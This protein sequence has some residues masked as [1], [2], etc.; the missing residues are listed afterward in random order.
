MGS[1]GVP[2]RDRSRIPSDSSP[3]GASAGSDYLR[4][5][6]VGLS[7]VWLCAGLSA[8]TRGPPNAVWASRD[9][10]GAQRILCDS[11]K[12]VAQPQPPRPGM[13]R[14]ARRE[15]GREPPC[16]TLCGTP[17]VPQPG[18]PAASPGLLQQLGG[19]LPCPQVNSYGLFTTTFLLPSSLAPVSS[20]PSPNS[21]GLVSDRRDHPLLSLL[22]P[23]RCPTPPQEP[24]PQTALGNPAAL[25]CPRHWCLTPAETE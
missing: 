14:A 10:P 9:C 24:V 21:E 8:K 13:G 25:P 7:R 4:L 22:E 19:P 23:F 5:A 11:K 17:P 18:Q 1:L 15:M 12:P 16:R 3:S 2:L 6:P 20:A